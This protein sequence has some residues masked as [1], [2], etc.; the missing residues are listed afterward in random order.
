[1]RA[2]KKQH[3]KTETSI[4]IAKAAI[5]KREIS[6]LTKHWEYISVDMLTV[7]GIAFTLLAVI[8]MFE[9]YKVSASPGITLGAIGAAEFWTSVPSGIHFQLVKSWS[10]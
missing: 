3:L 4:L 7:K 2:R 1:M 8:F 5:Q 6:L 10:N 9:S